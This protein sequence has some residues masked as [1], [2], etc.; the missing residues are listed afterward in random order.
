[1]SSAFFAN[2]WHSFKSF[3]IFLIDSPPFSSFTFHHQH[4]WSSD[5]HDTGSVKKQSSL[6]CLCPCVCLCSDVNDEVTCDSNQ[7]T[8]ISC[9]PKSNHSASGHHPWCITA[10]KKVMMTRR[11]R[12]SNETMTETRR[13]RKKES[14]S[15][16]GAH[17][18]HRKEWN[19]PPVIDS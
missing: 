17:I 12:V 9:C 14:R 19:P 2:A 5:N 15:K 18:F 7:E 4:N 1:M 13:R 3:C 11:E 16:I 6:S 10:K 8:W